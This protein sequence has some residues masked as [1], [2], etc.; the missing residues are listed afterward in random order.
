MSTDPDAVVDLKL[1]DTPDGRDVA[2]GESTLQHQRDILLQRR[3]DD[4]F[5]VGV[6]VGAED[7]LLDNNLDDFYAAVWRQF[8]EDGMTDVVATAPSG[9][10]TGVPK[11]AEPLNGAP[12]GAPDIRS[13]TVIKNQSWRDLA[14]QLYANADAVMELLE[15]NPHLFEDG[16]VTV[17]LSDVITPGTTIYHDVNSALVNDK[18]LEKLEGAVIATGKI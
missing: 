9:I 3:G 16:A 15:L 7:Y 4:A 12:V 11:G 13:Y 2:Y 14:V 17:V 1:V 6:G 8:E 5:N 18:E 10:Y